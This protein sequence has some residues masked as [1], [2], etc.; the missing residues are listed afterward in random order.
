VTANNKF[1]V[2]RTTIVQARRARARFELAARSEM[3]RLLSGI[4]I[5]PH[6][7]QTRV[8]KQLQSKTLDWGY[9]KLLKGRCG[10]HMSM[11]C[12]IVCEGV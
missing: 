11:L 5:T 9:L 2:P 10:K 12:L 6:A 1:I 4:F 7:A 8:M 3:K